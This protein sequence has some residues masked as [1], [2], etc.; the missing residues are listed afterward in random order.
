MISYEAA[1]GAKVFIKG[2]EVLKDG[3]VG[4]AHS[5]GC[6]PGAPGRR[7][8]R[9][10]P[11]GDTNSP[12]RCFPM[13]ISPSPCPASWAAGR[14]SIPARRRHGAV[15]APAWTG[16]RRRQAA[17]AGGT[18]AR[19]GGAASAAVPRLHCSGPAAK[20]PAAASPRR[21]DHAGGRRLA[22]CAL[23]GGDVG[24]GHSDPS[25]LGNAGR[26]RHRSDHPSSRVRS[27]AER[28]WA[29]SASRG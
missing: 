15:S 4:A 29:S 18:T 28:R 2:S 9:R 5:G 22:R 21:T 26:S 24:T 11:H 20:R 3:W 10:S 7:R 19:T 23:L 1:P 6:G 17:G 8:R 12:A 25:G 13:P 27:R 16:V 14:G